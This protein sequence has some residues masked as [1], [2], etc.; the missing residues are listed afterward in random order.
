[1][2]NDR[3]PPIHIGALID[4]RALLQLSSPTSVSLDRS[5]KIRATGTTSSLRYLK[6][7]SEKASYTES[8]DSVSLVI[9]TLICQVILF[10]R[11]YAV[12]RRSRAVATLL[13]LAFL[14]LSVGEAFSSIYARVPNYNTDGNHHCTSGNPPGRKGM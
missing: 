13:G 11:T 3:V 2:L 7:R 5:Q 12:S 6:V 4:T 8:T 14:G 1:M 9:Q 10:V